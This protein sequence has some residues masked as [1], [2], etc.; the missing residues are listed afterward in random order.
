MEK[1]EELLTTFQ[2]SEDKDMMLPEPINDPKKR[3]QVHELVASRG[4]YSSTKK[5]KKGSRWV[6]ISK[7]ITETE[8]A[9][10]EVGIAEFSKLASIPIPVTLPDHLDYYLDIFDTLYQAEEKFR[11]Y[12]LGVDTHKG[13]SR[14]RSYTLNLMR[15]LVGIINESLTDSN[16]VVKKISDRLGE[17]ETVQPKR[18]SA[19]SEA[20]RKE[21]M[22][23]IDI[24]SANFTMLKHWDLVDFGGANNWKEWIGK[25]TDDEFLIGSKHFRQMVLGTSKAMHHVHRIC[26]PYT[27]SLAKSIEEWVPEENYFVVIYGDEIVFKKP[28]D[29]AMVAI[30]EAMSDKPVRVTEYRLQE[31]PQ[32]LGLLKIMSDG[33]KELKAVKRYHASLAAKIVDKKPI[34]GDQRDYMFM[35]E[36]RPAVFL[37]QKD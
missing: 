32:N 28:S 29:E 30:R 3:G 1:I 5:G 31:L 19:Y 20:C 9:R 34:N 18:G 16:A 10:S 12:E 33:K 8:S 23:S 14:Y 26:T 37:D 13:A 25:H 15:K 21:T 6:M 35:Y 24:I 27:A 2:K 17:M 11:L 4:L 7:E 36:G 22:V